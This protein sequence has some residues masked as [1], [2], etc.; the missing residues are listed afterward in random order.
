MKLYKG[1][2]FY[3][4]YDENGKNSEPFAWFLEACGIEVQ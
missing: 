4:R 3:G 2:E 1:C